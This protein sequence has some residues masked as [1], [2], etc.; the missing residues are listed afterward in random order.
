MK[1]LVHAAFDRD[2]PFLNMT[3]LLYCAT[4]CDMAIERLDLLGLT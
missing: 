4:Y 1:N 2:A 3:R